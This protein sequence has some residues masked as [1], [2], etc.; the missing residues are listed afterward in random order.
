MTTAASFTLPRL[1][2]WYLA[3]IF[4]RVK[5]LEYSFR[6]SVNE[7][8]GTEKDFFTHSISISKNNLLQLFMLN[9]LFSVEMF[10][11]GLTVSEISAYLK[12]LNFF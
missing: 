9:T 3:T 5:K 6:V 2:L 4:Y 10:T 8:S 12:C 7:K 11:S 1:I